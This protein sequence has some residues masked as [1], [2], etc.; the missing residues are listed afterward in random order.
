VDIRSVE[1]SSLFFCYSLGA[2]ISR[3]KD[4]S[5]S[6][7][8]LLLALTR[9]WLLLANVPLICGVHFASYLYIY[10]YLMCVESDRLQRGGE[11]ESSEYMYI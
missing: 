3:E 7:R 5:R 8:S 2:I 1:F 10:I 4:T 11:E 9:L 6:F